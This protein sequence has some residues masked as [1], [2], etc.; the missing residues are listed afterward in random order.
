MT[1]TLHRTITIL[2]AIAVMFAGIVIITDPSSLG[3]SAG[4]WK[5]VSGWI[6]LGSGVL[7][8]LATVIRANLFPGVSTGIGNELPG[9]VKTTTVA[10]ETKVNP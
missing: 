3:V 6:A 5:L 8:G 7:S 10:T 1:G 4:T 2:A 9:I